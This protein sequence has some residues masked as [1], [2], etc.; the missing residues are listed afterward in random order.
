MNLE[1]YKNEMNRR[2]PDRAFVEET[3]AAAKRNTV[4]PEKNHRFLKAAGSFGL[5][6]AILVG[7]FF[8]AGAVRSLFEDI[9]TQNGEEIT[10]ETPI[11]AEE[12]AEA[13][14]RITATDNC[15]AATPLSNPKYTVKADTPDGKVSL[16]ENTTPAEMLA[17]G[18]PVETENGML[19]MQY[20]CEALLKYKNHTAFEFVT[21]DTTN[22][23]GNRYGYYNYTGND[24]AYDEAYNSWYSSNDTIF[25]DYQHR[26]YLSVNKYVAGNNDENQH[27]ADW[28]CEENGIK[29]GV[30]LSRNNHGMA[31]YGIVTIY[32][33]LGHTASDNEEEK[34]AFF[35]KMTNYSDIENDN[36]QPLLSV[37]YNGNCKGKFRMN[38]FIKNIENGAE[39]AGVQYTDIT[40]TEE[41]SERY[42]SIEYCQ[43]VYSIFTMTDGLDGVFDTQYFDG[44]TVENNQAVFDNG[45][46]RY[47]FDLS[48]TP[49]ADMA[50]YDEI[51]HYADRLDIGFY[52]DYEYH[53]SNLNIAY[54]KG[55]IEQVFAEKILDCI[56]INEEYSD[57]NYKAVKL[58]QYRHDHDYGLATVYLDPLK[59]LL[60]TDEDGAVYWAHKLEFETYDRAFTVIEKDG[61]QYIM[62]SEVQLAKLTNTGWYG[63]NIDFDYGSATRKWLISENI[64][65]SQEIY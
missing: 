35:Y 33:T 58:S 62:L 37:I 56:V 21:A 27:F 38:N 20:L 3:L 25:W 59:S 51:L 4:K 17:C 8:G 46:V 55:Y 26:G 40:T 16:D 65:M 39:Y 31:L 36:R 34:Q 52:T 9:N 42:Y 5:S 11:T 43:G 23:I 14:D 28:V 63:L 2:S 18:V 45:T 47:A 41:Y 13:E 61:E 10:Q 57:E 15:L 19:G 1:K 49:E 7:A 44:Y 48:E 6:A 54:N 29:S 53:G 64:Y 30:A 50:Q 24:I 12:T 32:D 22:P 60:F